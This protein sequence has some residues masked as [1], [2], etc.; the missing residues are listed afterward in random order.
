MTLTAKGRD[1]NHFASNVFALDTPEDILGC[2]GIVN[3]RI[4]LRPMH[5]LEVLSTWPFVYAL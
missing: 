3:E 2:V 5:K 1:D 4:S